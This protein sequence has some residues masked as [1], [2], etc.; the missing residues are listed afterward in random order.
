MYAGRILR[1][2]LSEKSVSI[3]K[4][5]KRVYRELVGGSGI[6][7]DMHLKLGSHSKDPFSP[8]N[9]I[10]IMNGPLTASAPSCSKIQFT[11]RSPLTMGWGESNVGG[12]M[13]GYMK[14]AGWD[15]LIIEGKSDKPV[16]IHV[17][18]DGA[19]IRDADHL[20]GRTTYETMDIL[21]KDHGEISAASI[22]P[23][24]EN[25]VRYG[26]I[27]A[28]NSRAAGRTGIGAVMG[29][30]KLKAIAVEKDFSFSP[31]PADPER[32]REA[33]RELASRIKD[34]FTANMFREVGTGGYVESAEMFG[35]LPVK[36]F[37]EGEFGKAERISSNYLIEKY[38]KRHDGCMGCSIKCGKILN[39]NGKEYHLPEYETLASF[40]SLLM[41]DSGE[42]LVEINHLANSLGLDT[43]SCG[44]TIGM[45]MHLTER[46]LADFGIRF[47]EDDKVKE[48]LRL[49]A[50]REGHGDLLAEGTMRIEEELGLDGVAAHVRGLEIPM[51]DPR[52][53]F[54]LAVAY[55]TNNR[56]ACHLP[57]QMYNVEMGLKIKEY[58]I[59]S[60]GRFENEGKGEI[61]AKM[62]NFA[63]I[64][65]CLVMCVFVPAKPSHISALLTSG[66]G[67]DH[68][69][70]R[71]YSIGERVFNLK[72]RYNELAG[73]GREYDRLPE[74]VLKPLPGGTEGNV[75]DLKKQLDEYY[76]FRGW[77]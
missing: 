6:A 8:E 13:A 74:I 18:S 65:N 31:E 36:Y 44:V 68:T 75:P 41:I 11:A 66:T 20:W 49:I 59:A 51:H 48:Y 63:E 46:N 26:C 50:Y 4:P 55:A 64:F 53:F 38:F 39:Y 23:A 3:Y 70:E 34:N 19:E 12:K 1:V 40:G 32:F 15:G 43:I 25:L 56:G 24:G 47:G 45:A 7:V 22:G 28:D 73:R 27:I 71:I 33:V 5:E 69:P 61:T 16:Y 57:H 35:D 42:S 54:S 14:K 77:G 2:N 10:V 9:P 62:Q 60:S 21:R 67:I 17:T 76:R 58:G 30:K 52:A 37:T 29:S 72:R